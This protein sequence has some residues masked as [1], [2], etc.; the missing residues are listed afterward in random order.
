MDAVVVGQGGDALA[1]C[2]LAAGRV[3]A[4]AGEL[5]WAQN[6]QEFD[7][8]G[9]LLSQRDQQKARLLVLVIALLLTGWA[10]KAYRTAHPSAGAKVEVKQ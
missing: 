2:Q 3:D 9:A 1:D 4:S 6:A 8:L 7:I 5:R 10:V